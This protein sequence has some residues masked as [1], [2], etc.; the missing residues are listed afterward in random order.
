MIDEY[1]RWYESQL[2][3][4]AVERT[5][6]TGW[7]CVNVRSWRSETVRLIQ[8]RGVINALSRVGVSV[9]SW[10][11][12][13]VRLTSHRFPAGRMWYRDVGQRPVFIIF[14]AR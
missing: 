6:T 7:D 9:R 10:R 14:A 4:I 8:V 5:G 3:T 13:T 12:E 11:L 2:T 1:K